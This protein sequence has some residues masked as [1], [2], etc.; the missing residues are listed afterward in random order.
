MAFVFAYSL[1]SNA[2]QAIVDLPLDTAGNFAVAQQTKGSLVK[3]VSGLLQKCGT[4]AAGTGAVGVLE[5]GEFTGL[6]AQGQPYAATNASQ[7]ASA[8]DT[9]AFPN[10]VGKV[11]M[12]KA[13]VYK[14]KAS[15]AVT[16]ANIGASYGITLTGSDQTVNI[17]D[18]TNL[19]VK[20]VQVDIP[21]QYVYVTIL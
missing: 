18:T 8:T 14:V 20:V 17:A 7:I 15:A 9:T 12:D 21:N 5:G 2:A 11:R 1:D 10:G 3:S 4:G 16:N 19:A 6:V 13:A